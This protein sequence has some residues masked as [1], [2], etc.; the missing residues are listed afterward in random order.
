VA[1]REGG[2]VAAR[3]DRRLSELHDRSEAVLQSRHFFVPNHAEP[4]LQ[5]LLCHSANL[6]AYRHCE[7]PFA[8]D[9]YKDRRT[10]FR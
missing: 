4:A 9:R 2:T 6:V 7:A 1:R 8:R 5:A 10:G 3:F